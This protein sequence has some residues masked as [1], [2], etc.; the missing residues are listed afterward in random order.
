MTVSTSS[1]PWFNEKRGVWMANIYLGVDATGRTKKKRVQAPTRSG[2]IA[3]REEVARGLLRGDIT[4]GTVP[5]VEAWTTYWVEKILPARLRP[6]PLKNYRG[7]VRHYIVPVIGSLRLDKVTPASVRAVTDTAA[8]AGLK[9]STVKVIHGAVKVMLR[10][11][12]REGHLRHNPASN[13]DAPVGRVERREAL[14]M[15][16]AHTLLQHTVDHPDA[17]TTRW[18]VALL[19]GLRQGEALGLTWDRVDLEAG[20]LTID[21]QLDRLPAKHGCGGM[22]FGTWRCGYKAPA[23]CPKMI[24]DVHPSTEYVQLHKNLCLT[25][26]KTTAGKRVVPLPDQLTLALRLHRLHY[27]YDNPHG[28]VWSGKNGNPV[29]DSTDTRRWERLLEAAGVRPIVLHGARHT[30]V[31]LLLEVG[32]PLEIIPRIVGHSTFASTDAYMHVPLDAQRAALNTYTYTALSGK[33]STAAPQM[34]DQGLH[35]TDVPR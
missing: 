25:P 13:M 27:A 19:L 23:S 1:K 20:T 5:T 6:G 15:D 31:S 17:Y 22:S 30:A 28:L 26:T 16:E 24:L 10:D 21:R 33:K 2:V 35:D 12:V 34:L 4:P 32:V 8:R 7:Y 18:M 14:T 9:S 11:A 29:T 3:K